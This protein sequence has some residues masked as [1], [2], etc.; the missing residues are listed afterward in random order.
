MKLAITLLVRDEIDIVRQWM[1]YHLPLADTMV[2]TDNGSVDGTREILADYVARHKDKIILIDEPGRDFQQNAWADR[3]IRACQECGPDWI[4]NSDVDEFWHVPIDQLRKI[5]P[6]IGAYAVRSRNIVPTIADD[7]SEPCPIKRI[8]WWVSEPR[9]KNEWWCMRSWNK[10]IHRSKG[11]IANVLGN[12]TVQM[13]P[14]YKIVN[15]PRDWY[16][17][18]Y[19][20]RS[21]PQYR[22]KYINGGEAYSMSGWE[23]RY[24]FHWRERYELYAGADGNI[25]Q[26]KKKWYEEIETDLLKL[27]HVDNLDAAEFINVPP[28]WR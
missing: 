24:G 23:S 5:A 10:V 18:H 16:I 27:E 11:W 6:N 15:A 7:F 13:L 17:D 26:L 1:D 19:S 12:H 25:A 20:N 3:M 8:K 2:I 28:D 22:R 21:W 14:R 9:T 4:M